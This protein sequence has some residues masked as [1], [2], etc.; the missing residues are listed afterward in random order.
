MNKPS[1]SLSPT[2]PT[3][4]LFRLLA[5]LATPGL[6]AGFALGQTAP[7]PPATAA[8]STT[9]DQTVPV[10]ANNNNNAQESAPIKLSPFEVNSSQDTGY[11]AGSALSGT[12]LRSSLAD[13]PASISV[14]TPDFM[15]DVDA[16][17]LSS[18]LIYTTGTEVSGVG[19]NFSGALVDSQFID[20]ETQL[21]YASPQTRVRGLV[22]AD[23]AEDFFLTQTPLDTYNVDQVEI[24]RGANAMLYGL[25]SP[26][27]IIN[28]D[29]KEADVSRTKGEVQQNFGEY[30]S[31]RNVLDYNQV[32]L[33][34]K[35]AI[36]VLTLHNKTYYRIRDAYAQD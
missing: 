19:G 7:A 4:T 30:G 10:V 3:G 20:F 15:Q 16:T 12:R 5:F 13:L 32:L 1:L 36:R 21:Q 34:N 22:S 24:S 9:P 23:T 17:D 27:G 26:G 11:L 2:S 29:L 25:G 33:K 6:L 31:L 35:L 18:L 28:Y 14:I 8:Q